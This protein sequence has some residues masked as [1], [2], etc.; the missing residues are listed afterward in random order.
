MKKTDMSERASPAGTCLKFVH[1]IFRIIQLGASCVILGIYSYFLATLHNHGFTINT[2]LRSV[3]GISGVGVCYT[4]ICILSLCCIGGFRF[5]ILAW[6]AVLLD[7]AFTGAYA[8]V[9]WETR[10]GAQGCTGYVKTPFG[11]G[12]SNLQVQ[13]PKGGG[14]ALPSLHQA[15]KLQTAAFSVS[16]IAT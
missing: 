12:D 6:L 13:G 11:N 4:A 5:R 15:C 14:T 9:I 1:F 2:Y 8:Y 3:E 10:D 7:I 16:I